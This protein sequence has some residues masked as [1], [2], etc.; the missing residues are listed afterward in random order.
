MNPPPLPHAAQSNFSEEYLEQ[1]R[2]TLR[3]RKLAEHK[4]NVKES[5]FPESTFPASPRRKLSAKLFAPKGQWRRLGAVVRL[6]RRRSSSARAPPPAVADLSY[7][8]E[9]SGTA[10]L[11]SGMA[12]GDQNGGVGGS[13]NSGSGDS[14]YADSSGTACEGAAH[15]PPRRKSSVRKA[16]VTSAAAQNPTPSFA[17][18]TKQK[19][20]KMRSTTHSLGALGTISGVG[21]SSLAISRDFLVPGYVECEVRAGAAV[22]PV[23]RRRRGPTLFAFGSRSRVLSVGAG[24]LPSRV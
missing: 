5:A 21:T 20:Q 6:S 19:T 3:Q 23:D 11:A 15:S 17:T 22:V 13:A 7:R 12:G 4:A 10:P 2:I 8:G 1:N 18:L 16:S 24:A 14:G 9:A